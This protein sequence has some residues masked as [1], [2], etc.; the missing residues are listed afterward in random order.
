[1]RGKTE[2]V[3]PEAEG[4]S[5][6]FFNYLDESVESSLYRNGK[7]L[8][9]RDPDGSDRDMQGVHR[10]KREMTVHDAR[11][12]SGAQ[13]RS[14]ASNGFELQERPLGRDGLDFLDQQQVMQDYYPECVRIVEEATGGRAFAFD[15]NVRSALGKKSR[16]R[17]AGGQQVQ[18]PAHMVHGDYTLT[19]AP[20]RLRDL[21]KPPGGNDT[22]RTLLGANESLISKGD[23]EHAL[24]DGSRFAIINLWRNISNEPVVSHP[25][26]LCD[27]QTVDPEDLVVFEIHYEDRVGENYF[28]KH[29]DRHRWYYF[30][31][32]T[33]DEALLIKQWDSAGPLSRSLGRLGDASEAASPST[34]SF[35]SAFED[36]ATLPDA[37]DRRSIEVRCIV[38]YDRPR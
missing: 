22:L 33:G 16:M 30:P 9:R 17:I 24:A 8:I 29:A 35:H 1:M 18:A 26:A 34:F 32:I 11:A 20:Q 14:L 28:A 5:L 36:P 19:S 23:A 15:H 3:K 25:L 37:P 12:L 4:H 2:A 27:S 6:G 10:A 31:E 38:L 7:V 21:S 13:A